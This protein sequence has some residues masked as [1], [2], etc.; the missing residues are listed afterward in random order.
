[1]GKYAL[2]IFVK[3]TLEHG[4]PFIEGHV[5]R[6]WPIFQITSLRGLQTQLEILNLLKL[7]ATSLVRREHVPPLRTDSYLF[8]FAR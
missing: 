8:P 5:L 2:S 4:C 1:M 7:E 6:I 3:K